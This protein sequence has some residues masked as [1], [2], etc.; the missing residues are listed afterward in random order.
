M[1]QPRFANRQT[2]LPRALHSAFV[3]R[4]RPLPLS[5]PPRMARSLSLLPLTVPA[6]LAKVAVGPVA[7]RAD[8][9][10]RVAG[11]GPDA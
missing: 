9:R 1:A 2:A 5:P 10:T 4:Q 8:L 3:R 6:L 11:G 7:A